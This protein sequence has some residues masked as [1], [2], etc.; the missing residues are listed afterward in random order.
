MGLWGAENR[1]WPIAKRLYEGR[2]DEVEQGWTALSD[3]ERGDDDLRALFAITFVRNG[4]T[5]R[6]IDLYPAIAEPLPRVC[7]LLVLPWLLRLWNVIFL[8]MPRVACVVSWLLA[9]V[10]ADRGTPEL[11]VRMYFCQ[12]RTQRAALAYALLLL[13]R[14]TRARS[15]DLARSM[16]FYGFL[17]ALNGRADDGLALIERGLARWRREYVT[18]HNHPYWVAEALAVKASSEFYGG[19][20]TEALA[21]HRET[22][23]VFDDP[24]R[25]VFCHVFN[26]AMRLRTALCAGDRA[27]FEE[28]LRVLRLALTDQFDHR[29]ALRIHASTAVFEILAGRRE[30][31]LRE[32]GLADAASQQ[33]SFSDFERFYHVTQKSKVYLCE[34]LLELALDS[35]RQAIVGLSSGSTTGYFVVDAYFQYLKC[36]L[37]ARALMTLEG[38]RRVA[39]QREYARCVRVLKRWTR[40]AAPLRARFAVLSRA[41]RNAARWPVASTLAELERESAVLGHE[42]DDVLRALRAPTV[43]QAE[44]ARYE[45][46]ARAAAESLQRLQQLSSYVR[47]LE[48][49][50]KAQPQPKE[51]LERALPFLQ[52]VLG[53]ES[54]SVRERPDEAPPG[55]RVLAPGIEVSHQRYTPRGDVTFRFAVADQL[56]AVVCERCSEHPGYRNDVLEMLVLWHNITATKLNEAS[57]ASDLVRQQ[58]LEAIARTTQMLAHDVRKPFSLIRIAASLMAGSKTVDEAKEIAE[59]VMPEVDAA[60]ESVTGMLQDVLLF[61]G[62]SGVHAREV[63]L[64]GLLAKS[65]GQ[66]ALMY[67]ASEILFDYALEHECLL[68]VEASK[69]ER[70][71]ANIIANAFQAMKQNGRMW[72]AAREVATAERR[73]VELTIGNSGSSIAE[74]DRPHIFEAFVSRNKPGGTGLGLAIARKIVNDHGGRIWVSSS[75]R[76]VEFKLTLPPGGPQTVRTPLPP[77]GRSASSLLART[78][79]AT[80]SSAEAREVEQ[81]L[82]ERLRR[83]EKRPSILLVDDEQAY[84]RMLIAHLR[85]S[86]TLRDAFIIHEAA[87][88]GAALELARTQAPE[89]AFV[90]IDLGPD[91]PNGFE[92]V[93]ELRTL[94]PEVFICMHSNRTRSSD[95]RQTL[96]ADANSY[97]LK[98]M[99]RAHML[100]MLLMALSGARGGE[101]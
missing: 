33:T 22:D 25:W 18:S 38:E 98:P 29:F 1:Y 90:D 48:Q 64:D 16:W 83:I 23:A 3:A 34:G 61:G 86:A 88:A 93:R 45:G 58:R 89:I 14:N 49:T 73:M 8:S 75:A 37:V 4:A 62:N 17:N 69:V 91:V 101:A 31:S 65:I 54:A 10:M 40:G 77:N 20:L 41:C 43:R 51:T 9:P 92:L 50:V 12:W 35:A 74:A 30:E 27:T 5:G 99:A 21:T 70:V 46:A 72:F 26:N 53:Y 76:G 57:R 85:D 6:A 79:D 66:V 80:S 24:R 55:A 63:A 13:A 52:E 32:L 71:L 84:R 36:I 60:L 97:C 15:P 28:T 39:I 67:P 95:Y 78:A 94:A 100:K 11:F 59:E 2:L 7:A 87:S 47:S 82:V 42:A 44:C 19:R 81:L 56:L 68:N 96:E